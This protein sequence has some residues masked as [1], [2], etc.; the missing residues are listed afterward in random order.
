MINL[1]N[2]ILRAEGD[3]RYYD[4]NLSKSIEK[5]QKNF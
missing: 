1:K 2:K 5:Q 3:V 4:R